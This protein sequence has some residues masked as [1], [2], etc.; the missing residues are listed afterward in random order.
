ME[1]RVSCVLNVYNIR[2]RHEVDC[3]SS[4]LISR[5]CRRCVDR[6]AWSTWHL[7]IRSKVVH[8]SRDPLKDVPP[9]RH[10]QTRSYDTLVPRAVPWSG[11]FWLI[12]V[13]Y[14]RAVRVEFSKGHQSIFS[15]NIIVDRTQLIQSCKIRSTAYRESSDIAGRNVEKLTNSFSNPICQFFIYYFYRFFKGKQPERCPDTNTPP[16]AVVSSR[17][18]SV[19]FQSADSWLPHEYRIR[20]ML[21]AQVARCH[22]FEIKI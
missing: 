3:L 11:T 8:R 2:V 13:V 16:C 15:F 14:E 18:L 6:G 21:V 5:R 17:L 4:S 9:R 22:L 10:M 1:G 20:D 7:I 12:L 19:Q